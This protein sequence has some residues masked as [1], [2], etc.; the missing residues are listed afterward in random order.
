MTIQ[1][2]LIILL[3]VSVVFLLG[4]NF[5]N[6]DTATQ[7]LVF[8]VRFKF[9]V[10]EGTPNHEICVEKGFSEPCGFISAMEKEPMLTGRR[11]IINIIVSADSKCYKQAKR[12]VDI[13]E[14][15]LDFIIP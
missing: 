7:K 12:T 4:W 9:L 13:P 15:C 11:E 2:T 5:G 10:T 3:L 6:Q 14:S 8:P 1:N